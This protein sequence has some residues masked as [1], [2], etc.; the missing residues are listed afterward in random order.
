DEQ[1]GICRVVW[2]IQIDIA[3]LR[4]P[5]LTADLRLRDL[6]V[7]ALAAS[8][9]ELAL[10][11]SAV[12]EDPTGGLRD[13]MAR[14]VRPCGPRVMVDDPLRALRAVRFAIKPGWRLDVST[15]VAIREAAPRMSEVS[16]ER[17]RDE[18]GE[19]LAAPAAAA[20][21]RLLDRLGLLTI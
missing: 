11:G 4:A 13:L 10:R 1:R 2:E 15:E 19:I 12:V 17:V 7:N 16:P 3:D 21:F 5:G 20:G 18:I 9:H 8:L 14:L 6:T